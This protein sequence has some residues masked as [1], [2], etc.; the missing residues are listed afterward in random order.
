MTILKIK[1]ITLKNKYKLKK[2]RAWE[3]GVTS[4]K[5]QLTEGQRGQGAAGRW[6]VKEP[7]AGTNRCRSPLTSPGAATA[8]KTSTPGA[9]SR[10]QSQAVAQAPGKT[11]GLC[12]QES[13]CRCSPP[14]STDFQLLG[15]RCHKETSIQGRTKRDS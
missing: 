14:T 4:R 9:G 11:M 8:T 13:S 15:I 10:V 6:L 2:E 5:A 7:E 12:S 3:I 1:S